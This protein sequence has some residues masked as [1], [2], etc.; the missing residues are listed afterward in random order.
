MCRDVVAS[1]LSERLKVKVERFDLAA[2][3]RLPARDNRVRPII[4]RFTDSDMKQRVMKQRKA[5]KGSR[6]VIQEDLSTAMQQLL[7]RVK[8]NQQ[9]VDA[10]AWNAKIFAKDDKGTIIKV[11]FGENIAD[12]FRNANAGPR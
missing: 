7:N 6:V 4:V 12:L 3:H 11:R 5:L 10:W 9:V 2:A 8:N 1:L